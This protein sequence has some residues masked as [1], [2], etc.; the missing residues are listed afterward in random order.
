MTPCTYLSRKFPTRSKRI[1]V[2]ARFLFPMGKNLVN[3]MEFYH[4]FYSFQCS[5]HLISATGYSTWRQRGRLELWCY[6]PFRPTKVLWI[7]S[8]A[9]LE[10]YFYHQKTLPTKFSFRH[11]VLGISATHGTER[12]FPSGFLV[13]PSTGWPAPWSA[14]EMNCKEEK[15]M[16][17]LAN[18][19]GEMSN[20][21]KACIMMKTDDWS[22]WGP[23]F[24]SL[25]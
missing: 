19:V 2:I 14:N 4:L 3:E 1:D 15:S 23:L 10:P 5:Q 9:L 8:L 17:P 18:L 16:S 25:V 11:Q 22:I 21:N 7:L 24:L 20:N 12:C 6:S 13:C